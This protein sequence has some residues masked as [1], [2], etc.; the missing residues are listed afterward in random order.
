MNLGDKFDRSTARQRRMR[1]RDPRVS[2]IRIGVRPEPPGAST[3]ETAVDLMRSRGNGP[4]PANGLTPN[5]P[6]GRRPLP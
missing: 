6:G 3:P 1:G 4:Q 5:E 2:T